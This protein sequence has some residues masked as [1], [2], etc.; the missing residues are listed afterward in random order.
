VRLKACCRRLFEQNRPYPS[1]KWSFVAIFIEVCH[2]AIHP[3][4]AG[5]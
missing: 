2:A 5:P 4:P 3:W 1:V